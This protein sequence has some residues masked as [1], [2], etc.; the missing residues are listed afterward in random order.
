MADLLDVQNTQ[1]SRGDRLWAVSP[2]VVRGVIHGALPNKSNAK[3]IGM[4]KGRPILFQDKT[5]TDYKARFEDA[6]WKSLRHLTPLPEDARLYFK[7]VVY[8]QNLLRDL[9]CELLPDLL[10]KFNVI[11]NDRAIW[12]KD[13]ERRIDKE[14]PRA[15]FEIGILD[16]I[17]AA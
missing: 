5:V 10:Q 15:E 4:M 12:K 7:A 11:K 13:Y 6:V 1:P 2:G 17:G 9:D 14:N 16:G 3:R 8:Q